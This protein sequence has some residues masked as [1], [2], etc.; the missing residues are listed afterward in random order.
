MSIKLIIL[1]FD[2]TLVD[3]R[4]LTYNIIKKETSRRGYSLSKNY[5]RDMGD[6]PMHVHL[7]KE[8]VKK[9]DIWDIMTR[10]GI[11]LVSNI[12]KI[13]TAKNFRSLAKI[14][15]KKIILSNNNKIF[16]KTL[17]IK[18]GIG[19]IDE[20]HGQKEF[21][22]KSQGIRHVLRKKRTK[23]SEAVYV[24]DRDRDISEARK[25]GCYSVAISNRISWSTKKEI[26]KAR[27]DF[28]ISDLK[29]LN[30][31]IKRLDSL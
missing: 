25:A 12:G 6:F 28:I 3:T 26:L 30:F 10:I 23:P 31:V 1:D 20:V 11:D 14:N 21:H 13:K 7:K 15:K 9:K 22:S 24:G 17:L 19:F 8:G 5:K 4:D 2:G 27:P 16:I 29:E 18:F